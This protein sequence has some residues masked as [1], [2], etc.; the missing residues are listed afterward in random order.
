MRLFTLRVFAGDVVAACFAFE[1][2]SSSDEFVQVVRGP[3]RQIAM[4]MG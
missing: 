2:K 3:A 4:S 1:Q